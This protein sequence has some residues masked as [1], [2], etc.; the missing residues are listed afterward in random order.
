MKGEV[1]GYGLIFMILKCP[2][3]KEIFTNIWRVKWWN[4]KVSKIEKMNSCCL[5]NSGVEV[6]PTLFFSWTLLLSF[7]ISVLVIIV[8]LPLLFYCFTNR[9]VLFNPPNNISSFIT[10]II[11][12]LCLKSIRELYIMVDKCNKFNNSINIKIFVN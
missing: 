8:G 11:N 7:L 4:T 1:L 12:L 3:L 5:S 10:Y 9:L 6:K 2:L